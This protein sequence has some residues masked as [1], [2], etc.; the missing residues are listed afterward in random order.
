MHIERNHLK[1]EQEKPLRRVLRLGRVDHWRR[2]ALS[3]GK[4]RA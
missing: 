2:P 3:R 1:K 4:E